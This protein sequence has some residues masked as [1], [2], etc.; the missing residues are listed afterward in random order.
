MKNNNVEKDLLEILQSKN[1]VDLIY[2][3]MRILNGI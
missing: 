1:K 2:T 3:I